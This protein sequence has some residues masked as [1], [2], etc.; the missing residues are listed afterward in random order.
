MRREDFAS[1]EGNCRGEGSSEGS[2][3]RGIFIL[4]EQNGL[5]ATRLPVVST[6][7]LLREAWRK[8]QGTEPGKDSSGCTGCGHSLKTVS[9]VGNHT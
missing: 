1:A 6:T 8:Q 4:V 5:G 2:A 9:F 7:G 3:F